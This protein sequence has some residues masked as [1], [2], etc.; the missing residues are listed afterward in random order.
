MIDIEETIA[1][2]AVHP[3]S[4]RGAAGMNALRACADAAEAASLGAR[5]AC[6]TAVEN[7]TGGIPLDEFIAREFSE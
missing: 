3:S 2:V 1:R 5:L 4:G 6:V 7:C